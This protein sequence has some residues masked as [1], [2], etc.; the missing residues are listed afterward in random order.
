MDG[1]ISLSAATE[2]IMSMIGSAIALLPNLL[3]GIVVFI[4]FWILGRTVRRIVRKQTRDRDTRN[5]GLVFGRLAQG[6]LVILGFLIAA[7]IIFPF[8][9]ELFPLLYFL[10]QTV[11]G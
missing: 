7:T 11:N 3:I 8:T 9:F 5:V 4:I 1:N 10:I 6:V 2:K